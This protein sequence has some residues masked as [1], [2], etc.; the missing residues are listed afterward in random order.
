MTFLL[1]IM[2]FAWMSFAYNSIC[3]EAREGARFAIVHGSNSSSPATSTDVQNTV[4]QKTPGLNP[5]DLTVTTTWGSG[6]KAPGSTVNLRVQYTFNFDFSLVT[7]N[8]LTLT[9]TSQMVI[10]Q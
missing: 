4:T 5:A 2:P 7:L 8:A 3:N 6:S 10:L 1:G 9:S